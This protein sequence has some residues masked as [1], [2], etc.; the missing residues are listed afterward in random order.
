MPCPHPGFEPTKHWAACSGAREL[1]HSATGPAPRL[2]LLGARPPLLADLS[3]G[4]AQPRDSTRP[5]AADE[6]V[7]NSEHSPFTPRPSPTSPG[8]KWGVPHCL[9]PEGVTVMSQFLTVMSQFSKATENL[10]LTTTGFVNS[11]GR[12]PGARVS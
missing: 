5:T 6:A 1:N 2:C 10:A 9:C 7:T 3:Q 4:L 12:R 8:G 11:L